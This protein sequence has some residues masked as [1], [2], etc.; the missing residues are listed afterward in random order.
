MVLLERGG[1]EWSLWEK[2]N[3]NEM[4]EG[5]WPTVMKEMGGSHFAWLLILI[6]LVY[7]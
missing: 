7:P 4:G 2:K 5:S 3:V 6:K 1:E